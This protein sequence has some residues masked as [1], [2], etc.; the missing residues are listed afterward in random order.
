M[1]IE[2][3]K[4]FSSKVIDVFNAADDFFKRSYDIPDNK[5]IIINDRKN[6]INQNATFSQYL[7]IYNGINY[8]YMATNCICKPNILQET[9]KN[10]TENNEEIEFINYKTLRKIFLENKFNFN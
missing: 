8:D 2:S 4:N 6:D 3:A 5:D 1:D 7:C 9:K 10:I